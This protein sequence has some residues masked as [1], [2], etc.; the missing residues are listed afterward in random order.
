MGTSSFHRGIDVAAPWGTPVVAAR[1]GTVTFAGWS[2][3]GYGNLIKV[4][5]AGNDETWYA[6]FSSVAV[7]VGQQ[8]RQGQTIGYVGSTGLSTGPH[9]HFEL[10][11]AGRAVD[12]LS[13]L[14]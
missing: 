6:H 13:L 9:L 1:S 3:Q 2:T 14:R 10:Y 12:P 5:H 4:R 11:E 8:V 7:N